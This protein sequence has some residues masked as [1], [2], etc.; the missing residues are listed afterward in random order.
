MGAKEIDW[1]R[2]SIRVILIPELETRGFRTVP[3]TQEE[4]RSEIG[5]AFPFGRLSRT[6][7]TGIETVEVQLDKHGRPAFRLNLGT[8]PPTGI[9]HAIAGFIPKENVWVTYLDRYHVL[10]ERSLFRHWFSPSRSRAGA[11]TEQDIEGLVRRVV[12]VLDEVDALFRDGKR[13]PHVREV[14]TT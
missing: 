9:H 14:N 3:L 12:G 5:A 6:G 10:S 11:A 8:V 4:A 2:E 1:L 7:P 13:G